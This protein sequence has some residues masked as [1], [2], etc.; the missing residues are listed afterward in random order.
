MYNGAV[1]VME[2][3]VAIKEAVNAVELARTEVAILETGIV[4]AR[5]LLNEAA[6]R[7]KLLSEETT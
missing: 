3:E 4:A 5:L 1:R 7:L 6:H 2:N